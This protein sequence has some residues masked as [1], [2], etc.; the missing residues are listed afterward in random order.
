MEALKAAQKWGSKGEQRPMRKEATEATAGKTELSHI[1]FDGFLPVHKRPTRQARLELSLKGL[2]KTYNLFPAGFSVGAVSPHAP[3][4]SWNPDQLFHSPLPLSSFHRH[5]PAPPFLV[6]AVLD[7]LAESRYSS[8]T[9]V[10]PAEADVYCALAAFKLGGTILTSDSDL[11]VFNIG[12]KASVVF[13]NTLSISALDGDPASGSILK[14]NTFKTGEL[15]QKF[16]LPNLHRLTYEIKINP[17]LSFSDALRKT[18]TPV[19]HPVDFRAFLEE[20]ALP[21][22]SSSSSSSS[23]YAAT[24]ITSIDLKPAFLDP[25]LSELIFQLRSSPSQAAKEI[26]V[27]LPFFLDDPTRSSAWAVSACIRHTTY[28]FLT[29]QLSPN[30]TIAETS[31]QGYR[32]LSTGI[33]PVSDPNLKHLPPLLKA[34]QQKFPML[35]PSLSFRVFALAYIHQWHIDHDRKPPSRPSL[36]HALT[37]QATLQHHLSWEA[38]HLDAQVEGVLYA[39]RMLRQ[40]LRYLGDVAAA[41]GDSLAGL[42]EDHLPDLIDGLCPSR[43]EVRGLVVEAGEGLDVGCAMNFILDVEDEPTTN[44]GHEREEADGEQEEVAAEWQRPKKRKSGRSSKVLNSKAPPSAPKA[45][46]LYEL[47][48]SRPED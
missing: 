8:I 19:A 3:S 6:P 4:P 23:S 42:L 17:T 25:R 5:L 12:P 47:L 48:G 34:S 39:L 28:S 36:L 22:S 35:H 31:R 38:I 9:D 16:Q 40:S 45:R 27:Y 41:A 7:G 10:V 44:E 29:C 46:N 11:L 14:A 24:P 21:S 26:I 32:I 2:V 20:Y 1:Y 33:S 15:A 13:F 18:K 37:G 30:S 43:E